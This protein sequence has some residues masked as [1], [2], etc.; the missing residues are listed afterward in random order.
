MLIFPNPGINI[1]PWGILLLGRTEQ[2]P[3]EDGTQTVHYMHSK[4]ILL[5]LVKTNGLLARFEH[6]S[7]VLEVKKKTILL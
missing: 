3:N 1:V 5:K 7:Q 4:V 6:F 2:L